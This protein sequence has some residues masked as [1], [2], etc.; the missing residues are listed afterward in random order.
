MVL[1][2]LVII[3]TGV[4]AID[5]VTEGSPIHD[6]HNH[7]VWVTITWIDD[8]GNGVNF[9]LTKSYYDGWISVVDTNPGGTA[10]T[11]NYDIELQNSDGIDILNGELYDRDTSNSE[12]VRLT[13]AAPNNGMPTLVIPDGSQD[14]SGATG[15]ITLVIFT[16]ER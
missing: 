3:P 12:R 9:A 15:T 14:V 10:P 2:I 7:L 16:E 13:A 5:T 11:D 6:K 8:T 4:M 1:L